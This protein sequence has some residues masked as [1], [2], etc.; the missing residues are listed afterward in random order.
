MF[1]PALSSL[2]S[3][4]VPQ[5][6]RGVAYAFVV[7]NVG[8][9]S[10]PFPWIGSRMWTEFGPKVPFFASAVLA[11]LIIIPVWFKLSYSNRTANTDHPPASEDSA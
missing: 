10:L 3:K 9:I 5:R 11:S 2:I 1:Q 8:I 6:L 7:T 4:G